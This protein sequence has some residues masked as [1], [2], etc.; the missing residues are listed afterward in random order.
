MTIE[1]S[2][3]KKETDLLHSRGWIFKNKSLVLYDFTEK[4]YMLVE[5][6]DNFNDNE[7]FKIRLGVENDEETN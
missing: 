1:L 5:I 2:L 3:T 6:N 4:D 7:G